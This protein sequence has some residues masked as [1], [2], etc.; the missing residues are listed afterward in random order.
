MSVLFL[1]SVFTMNFHFSF[2]F[3]FALVL[4]FLENNMFILHV[5]VFALFLLLHATD[6]F[7]S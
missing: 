6:F 4:Y 5:C 7:D 2:C 3:S 1:I